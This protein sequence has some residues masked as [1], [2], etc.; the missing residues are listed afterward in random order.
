MIK[1]AVHLLVCFIAFSSHAE[2]VVRRRADSSHT[3]K[4]YQRARTSPDDPPPKSKKK[5]AKEKADAEY[6][7]ALHAIEKGSTLYIKENADGKVHTTVISPDLEEDEE[8]WKKNDDMKDFQKL[9]AETGGVMTLGSADHFNRMFSVIFDKINS[10]SSYSSP[11]LDIVISIDCTRSMYST[12]ESLKKNLEKL[13]K[14]VDALNK[15]GKKI[16]LGFITFYQPQFLQPKVRGRI[17]PPTI[18][19]PLT[20]DM[21]EFK[22][23]VNSI[24]IDKPELRPGQKI[25]EGNIPA[26]DYDASVLAANKMWQDGEEKGVRALMILTDIKAHPLTNDGLYDLNKVIK[27]LNEKE[28]IKAF[29]IIVNRD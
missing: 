5:K 6:F 1:G 27:L 3:D 10:N 21:D 29:P 16:R 14:R 12:L 2:D 9:A 22:Q 11:K 19:Q 15:K 17:P 20:E 18:V 28:K 25:Q 8:F 26:A 7:E 23:R 13:G 4:G 24:T